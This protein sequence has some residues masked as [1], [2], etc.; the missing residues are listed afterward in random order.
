MKTKERKE[1]RNLRASQ[2][3]SI[4]DIADQLGVSKS[5]VSL[6][7]RD[8][9]LTP[10]QMDNL[11]SR[12]LRDESAKA[13]IIKN[14]IK[15]RLNFQKEGRL[16][17]RKFSNNKMFIAGCI[18]YWAEGA[19][20]RGS[21]SMTNS[22]P[23]MLRLFVTFLENFFNVDKNNLSV[24]CRY[25]TDLSSQGEP[26]KYWLNALNL[27]SKCLRKS[28]VN[29]YPKT[30]TMVKRKYEHGKLR[31]GTCRVKIDSVEIMQQI[32]G[33]IQDLMGFEETRWAE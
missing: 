6:W 30:N 9:V 11:S 13:S 22:D 8:I 4:G 29:Y 15:R 18:A 5:S 17:A 23:N 7:T 1:A 26:E 33:A 25:Y 27:P 24:F 16:L 3:S 2:G 10:T 14:S 20:S 21:V 31:Y 32:Y 12:Q 28:C 19:K